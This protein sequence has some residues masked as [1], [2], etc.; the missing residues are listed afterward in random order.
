[1]VRFFRIG[2]FPTP[3]RLSERFYQKKV[4]LRSRFASEFLY[5][6]N[7]TGF[8][9]V[10]VVQE[11]SNVTPK[12]P[13]KKPFELHPR[14]SHFTW[15]NTR[16]PPGAH[17]EPTILLGKTQGAH[18][19]AIILLGKTQGVYQEP[20]ILLGKT[21]GAHQEPTIL[22]GKTQGTHQEPTRSP[23]FYLEKHKEPTR[24]PPFYLE[25]HKEP[26]RSPPFY[27]EKHKEP[28]LSPTGK[29]NNY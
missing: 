13:Y 7:G 21:Q 19:N 20:T 23:P 4:L 28:N 26:T 15:K 29:Y 22:L 17:Q 3:S 5:M 16:S 10:R 14:G 12:C 27:L 6:A 25:K 2:C 18:Q 1:M 8:G 9:T 11:Y 24:N